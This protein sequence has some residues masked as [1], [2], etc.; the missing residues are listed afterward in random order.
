MSFPIFKIHRLIEDNVVE[1]I[2]VFNGSSTASTDIFDEE[3]L[4]KI[5][6]E[7]IDVIYVEERIWIDD[8][9]GTI[10]TKILEAIRKELKEG[11][12]VEDVCSS[13]KEMYLYCLKNEKI[14]PVAIYQTLTHFDRYTFSQT[15]MKLLLNN[16]Y[17][18]N[19][20]QLF[21]S[22][23]EKDVYSFDDILALDLLNRDYLVSQILGQ[24]ASFSSEYPILC[25]PFLEETG[26][27]S[28]KES[29]TM[30]S[31]LLFDSGNIFKNTIYLCLAKDVFEVAD[32]N[33]VSTEY[34]S[35]IYFPFLFR[36]GVT[37]LDK[38]REQKGE[39]NTNTD[40]E[41]NL[42]KYFAV[43]GTYYSA[44][45]QQQQMNRK[46]SEKTGVKSIR[47]TMYPEYTVSK[48]VDTIFKLIHADKNSPL[49]KFNPQSRQENVYR[50]YTEQISTDGR[51]IPY[52]G[53]ATV[54]RLMRNIG[55]KRSVAVYTDV[56]Y[57]GRM[58][59]MVSEFEEKGTICVY[60]L[61]DFEEVIE[62]NDVLFEEIDTII[63]LTL[64]P[65]IEQIKPFFEQSGLDVPLFK[66]I[67][68]DTTEINNIQFNVN[69][70]IS[71]S[72]V[73][74]DYT[75]CL[76]NIYTIESGNLKTA[77]VNMRF[78]RV[79][80]FNK[81]DSQEAFILEKINQGLTAQEIIE[82]LMRTYDDLNEER[83]T[84][85]LN[86]IRIEMDT[87]LGNKH[88]KSVLKNNP[89]FMTNMRI[90]AIKSEL[91]FTIN[92]IN[93]IH[94]LLTIP[95]YLD[96]FVW[97]TQ[98]KKSVTMG[99]L[100]ICSS[101][102]DVVFEKIDNKV[103]NI[104]VELEPN[105]IDDD[106]DDDSN[107]RENMDDLLG[108]LN[109]EDEEEDEKEKEENENESNNLL[110]GGEQNIPS[111]SS[112]S[113]LVLPA[114]TSSSSELVLPAATSTTSSSSEPLLP[115]ATSTTSSSSEPLLPAATSSS[116]SEL[117]LPA[118]TSSSS[119]ELVLPAATSSILS[120]LVKLQPSSTSLEES[121][122]SLF[123]EKNSGELNK[124]I[125]K[126]VDN[127][128]SSE[129]EELEE[130]TEEQVSEKESELGS[131]VKDITGMRLKYPNPFSAKLEERMPQLFV[132]SK[133][134]KID[135]Y[136]RMCPFSL[137]DRRQPV[138]LTKEEKERILKEHPGDV[139]EQADFMEYVAD[140]KKPDKKFYYTC[141]R[142]WCL[143]T[144]TMVTEADILA[145]KC[146]PKVSKVEDAIIPNN[147]DVVPKD[148]Y[149]YQFHD[150]NKKNYP[151]FHNKELPSGTCIPCCYSNWSTP[152]RKNRRDICQGKHKESDKLEVGEEER[153][154]EDVVLKHS[155]EIEN[156]IKGPEKYG[157]QLGEH[158]W[159]F[160]PVS[161]QKFL[162][163]VCEIKQNN[164]EIQPNV[165]C[166]LRHGVEN[167]STQSFIGC[168][169]SAMFYGQRDSKTNKHLL[170]KF[171]PNAKHD[172]P[173]N[174]EMKEILIRALDLDIFVRLQN[175]E[176]LSVF[177]KDEL[178]ETGKTKE[179][180]KSLTAYNSSML[181]KKMMK[182]SEEK[183]ETSMAF[184][185]RAIN[186][187]E[188]FCAFLL[189][190]ST[191]IDYTYLWDFVCMPNPKLFA[192]GL[193]LIIFE[194]PEDDQTNNINL[195]C[196]TNHYSLHTYDARKRSLIIV[197]RENF[198]EPIYGYNNTESRL[199]VTTTFSEYDKKLPKTLRAVFSKIIKPTIGDKCR[200]L[201]SKPFEYR[202]KQAPLLD[203]L[204]NRVIARRYKVKTQV[205]NFQGKVI[206]IVAENLNGISGF[207]PCLPSSLTNLK[208]SKKCVELDSES[209]SCEYPFVYM[210]DDIWLPY[211][212][213]IE[214][215][216]D[217]Y[218][219]NNNT[220][221]K[222]ESHFYQVVEDE[223]IIGFLTDTNQFIQIQKPIPIS[224]VGEEGDIPF[225]RSE[226]TLTADIKTAN[227]NRVDTK[228]VDYI[229]R[230]KLES[231][232]FNV[233]RNTI[234]I[235]L[236]NYLNSQKRKKLHEIC[237][238]NSLTLDNNILYKH[239]LDKVIQL[240]IELVDN[241]IVF[242]EEYDYK[243]I[244]ENELKNCV[245]TDNT[246]N[247]CNN[248]CVLTDDKCTLVLPKNNLVTGANNE[249]QYFGRM[250]DELLR[251]N[252]IKS[253]IF[254]PQSYLSFGQIKYNLRDNEIIVL[255]DMLTPEFFDGFIVAETNK[256]ARYNTVGNTNP[257]DTQRYTN[258]VDLDKAIQPN[259]DIECQRGDP[260]I[261]FSLY[262]RNIFPAEQFKEVQYGSGHLCSMFLIIDLLKQFKG[263]DVS[264]GDVK[265]ELIKG[266]KVLTN[267]FKNKDRVD[268]IIQILREEAQF[269]ANQLEDGTM[270]FEQMILHEGFIAINFDLWILLF[271]Y[272]I[273]SI[274]ISAKNINET[275]FNENI[276]VCYMEE[277]NMESRREEY[278]VIDTPA[279]YRRIN[280]K[281]PIYKSIININA[282]ANESSS[283]INISAIGEDGREVFQKAFNAYI[284]IEEYLDYVFHK[285]NKTKYIPKKR[286]LRNEV[287]KIV[288]KKKLKQSIQLLEDEK[289]IQAPEA[290]ET[291]T[292][293]QAPEADE[294]NTIIQAP[295]AELSK[296]IPKLIIKKKKQKSL[297]LVVNPQGK[298][299]ITKKTT[300]Y[301]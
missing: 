298:N 105:Y 63:R 239:R 84:D 64:N 243:E 165:H 154:T 238:Q 276:F 19:G 264:I 93:N 40:R 104:D 212:E 68:D 274:F 143:L 92:G 208:R 98:E 97:L 262:W 6:E 30:D 145:G 130:E 275:R 226:N 45:L 51:K 177:Y 137:S 187:Y 113:E 150:K 58:Y 248:A 49:I 9:I 12:D 167:S 81:H 227:N 79:S 223:V 182:Q 224:E 29:G 41:D 123:N 287:K 186:A 258:E 272:K 257:M 1:Q 127:V 94:Y 65:L 300:N 107:S 133:N 214:F 299:N 270:T 108:I 54:F 201:P 172:V 4:K 34:I 295:E 206:G 8:N 57:K 215:I 230:I 126:E 109:F 228:R 192:A 278:A 3:E 202:F 66:S 23:E 10:K 280:G 141:P 158:R 157:P 294:T 231:G 247:S 114:A 250:A 219:T 232:F 48:P 7:E 174:K 15:R 259:D 205:L 28:D 235:L 16:L 96:V 135:L 229:K 26:E 237:F 256:Y 76:S 101:V 112:S 255:Q 176:L 2:Y 24:Q 241:N 22:I 178:T 191:T 18:I 155:A 39:I 144:D 43:I 185:F 74:S 46:V 70:K 122:S 142:F 277:N 196:P 60:S 254:K 88:R 62:L 293:I 203:D 31:L 161:L 164:V 233:F 35:K 50:L 128:D 125:P 289:D 281:I 37:N 85:M 198:F 194:I 222:K 242:V 160:L 148:R 90:D 99:F 61:E 266:Y 20:K 95:V 36:D 55:K 82:E 200:P 59:H 268:K 156:Y 267:G 121:L 14:N 271:Q 163:E 246:A 211:A 213:T 216:N 291:K 17:D 170:S 33:E 209:E 91:L 25:N 179:E 301:E 67:Q 221:N 80:N 199:L 153:I 181:Y 297:K 188:N 286:G 103:N 77:G 189:D 236:N 119:S 138:I 136:T 234:R 263:I 249:E 296:P 220:N 159:G 32:I 52:L 129:E 261:V 290:D 38:L 117:V 75:T 134:D 207:I 139:D 283:K 78:K 260:T 166:V 173:T 102:E 180:I 56:E 151:G 193:N 168:I 115:A 73:L 210:N 11:I 183:R 217:Y 124:D 265:K 251:Y 106:A 152:T 44:F 279:M 218:D 111:S 69:Y 244:D 292:I 42:R 171:I 162:H 147:A 240:L 27:T 284:P 140:P 197:Q 21:V 169:A 71:K 282:N 252:R 269:D 87:N 83:A 175:G 47:I 146:G 131:S 116:S 288:K 253:Y 184:L 118:A 86:K 273:P 13:I 120:E 72:F 285:D 89:G 225:I 149:V 110:T 5:A 195:V 190:K 204:L 100:N 245:K 132:K 53:R